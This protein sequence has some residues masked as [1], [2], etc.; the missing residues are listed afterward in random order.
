MKFRNNLPSVAEVKN[1]DIVDYL[2]SLGYKPSKVTGNNYWYLS[3]LRKEQ[4]PSFK[5]NRSMNRWY[6]FGDGEGGNIIDFGILYHC[7]SVSDF[8]KKINYSFSFRQQDVQPKPKDEEIKKIKVI[9]AKEITSLV[10]I[11]YLHKRRIPVEIANKFC[12]EV[13]YQLYNRNY[14]AIGFKNDSGGYELRNEKF[15]AGS[16]PKDITLIKNKAENLTVFEGFFNFLSYQAIHQRQEQPKTNFLILNSTSFFEKSLPLMQSY[17][18]VHLYLDCDTTGQKCIQK[19]MS[20]DE[21]KFVDERHLYKNYK[22]LNDWIVNIGNP[23]K[24]GLHLKL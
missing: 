18:S 14:Y 16:S 15:K 2:Q 17:N 13:N 7:C 12:K 3:P 24:Q 11:R 19:A 8:L 4:E 20:I 6:D 5:V 22:D 9:D 1:T 10:L 23:Q 21:Q